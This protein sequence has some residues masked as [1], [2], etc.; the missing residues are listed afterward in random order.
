RDSNDERRSRITAFRRGI[1]IARIDTPSF[2]EWEAI[3]R[4]CD[5]ATFFH[6]PYWAELW[7]RF[8][9]DRRRSAAERI[10]FS[11][12]RV[13][14]L[15]LVFERKLGGLLS[16]YTSSPE[17]TFGG[18]I[19]KDPLEPEH[20]DRLLS[21]LLTELPKS[22]VWRMNPFDP[23]VLD[24]GMRRGLRCRADWTHA[25]ALDAEPDVL[26]RRFRHGCRDDIRKAMKRG[27]ISVEPARSPEEWRAYYEIYQRA[28]ARWGLRSDQG[29]PWELFECMTN[30]GCA[31]LT[32]WFARYDGRI[33]SGEV[34]LYARRHV[35]SWHAAT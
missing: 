28:L 34:C 33:V 4:A 8:M 21:R 16:R 13:A 5:Y 6:S 22:L 17:G 3:W 11:D 29:Y 1:T 15:P 23:L 24:A 35:V 20:A 14:I 19:A 30:L 27:R 7:Q 12:G 25:V 26:L 18:W 10:T 9:G 31:E 2:R 32:L